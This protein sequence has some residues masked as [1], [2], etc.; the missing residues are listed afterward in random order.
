LYQPSIHSNTAMRASACVWKRVRSSTHAELLAALPEGDRGVLTTLEAVM[1]HAPGPPL[2]DRHL[3]RLQHEPSLRRRG[4]H[5]DV[6]SRIQTYPDGTN[7]PYKW[8]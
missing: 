5:P 3:E 1:D 2:P 4:P 7:D 8:S 6:S